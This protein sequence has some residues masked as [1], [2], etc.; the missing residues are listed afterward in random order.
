MKTLFCKVIV[1]M[2]FLTVQACNESPKHP[3]Q[4]S[5]NEPLAI[6]ADSQEKHEESDND[7][8]SAQKPLTNETSEEN[9]VVQV[10]QHNQEASQNVS[11]SVSSQSK[12]LATLE[13]QTLVKMGLYTAT[14]DGAIF[15][16][17]K[18]GKKYPVIF[19]NNHQ[20]LIASYRAF[21]T[22]SGQ[23]QFVKVVG[24]YAERTSS[25]DNVEIQHLV[26]FNFLEIINIQHCP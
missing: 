1:V 10:T 22:Q 5:P 16:D 11:Q 9:Q 17:C 24:E 25:E 26:L 15:T 23:R 6:D 3:I 4:E 7:E 2:F 13:T 12:D 18:T 21:S 20:Q 8:T 19:E 14:Q